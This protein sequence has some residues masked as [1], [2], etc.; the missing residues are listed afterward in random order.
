MY[1]WLTGDVVGSVGLAMAAGYVLT[2]LVGRLAV[3]IGLVDRPDGNRKAHAHPTPL[4]GGVAVFGAV[5]AALAAALLFDSS[6]LSRRVE[7]HSFTAMV[8]L[9][10]GLFC[11]VGLWD[12]KWGL[13]PR[14]KFL[15]QIAASL[16]F[17][18]W[19]RS[20]SSIHLVGVHFDLG[21]CG[22]AFTVFWLVACANIINL[23]DGLDG[24][25]GSIGLIVCLSIAAS[26][27]MQG[28]AGLVPL[29]LVIAASLLGFLMHNWPPAKIFLGDS[30]SL[31]IGF[32]IGALSIESSMKRATGFALA[33]PLVLISIPVFDTF[34]AIVRRKLSGRCIGAADR[35]HIHHCLQDRG[36]TRAQS[37]LAITGLCLAMAAAAL[38]AAYYKSDL[39]ALG[40]CLTL[41]GVLIAGRVFGHNETLLFLQ[42]LQTL[43]GLLRERV[44]RQSLAGK[45]C[46]S[47]DAIRQVDE[48]AVGAT[49]SEI[50][51]TSPTAEILGAAESAPSTSMP[52][53]PSRR[54]LLSSARPSVSSACSTDRDGSV[55]DDA[56][57]ERRAA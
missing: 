25:A 26:A 31:T 1:K 52:L 10:G 50:E 19:G 20:I 15:L 2:A 17:V 21:V 4:M 8:A 13:R 28:M 18:L 12:D 14:T 54:R 9:S 24:L 39:L 47:D 41:L 57:T 48:P 36:L 6:W 42:T 33:V 43:R 30:G 51:F 40:M 7:A 46:T 5:L 27:E 22:A 53:P 32:W 56:V 44:K 55:A 16:P 3:R 23:V 11:L 29:A 35:C 38:T 37:L 49:V 45:A 34:M